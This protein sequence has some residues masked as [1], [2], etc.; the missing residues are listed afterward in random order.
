M[1]TYITKDPRETRQVAKDLA[2][3]IKSYQAPHATVLAFQGDLGAGK[4]T[5]I[6]ALG[7][8]LGIK[9][10]LKSPTFTIMK[11]YQAGKRRV[12]HLDA[13]R[14]NSAKD[15]ELLGMADI[16]ADKNNIVLIE[17]AEKVREVLPAK[18]ISLSFE[19]ISET[20]R[21]IDISGI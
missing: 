12:F 10:V 16:L 17:W 5:F 9:E 11:G 21:K 2:P 4:T 20:E 8:A 6:Q 18:Y 13:Y 7:R 3:S 19:H 15:L 14:L 1:D